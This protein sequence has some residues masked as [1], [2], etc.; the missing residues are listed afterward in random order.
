MLYKK[1]QNKRRLGVQ[2]VSDNAAVRL[3]LKIKTGRQ[4][5]ISR[6]EQGQ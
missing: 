1:G 3:A 6:Q 4:I 2:D 5:K